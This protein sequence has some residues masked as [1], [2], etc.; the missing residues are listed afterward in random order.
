MKNFSRIARLCAAALA[1]ALSGSPGYAAAD[2][3]AA[4]LQAVVQTL[5]FLSNLSN[6]GA[7]NIGV[8]YAQDQTGSEGRAAQAAA[9]LNA[10]RGPN[11]RA[12]HGTPIAVKDL[13]RATQ[14]FDVYLLMPGTPSQGAA[15]NEAVR[16]RHTVSISTDPACLDANCCVLMVSAQGRV[17]IVLDS[18]L[19]DAAG[20]QFSSVF[21]MMVTRK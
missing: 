2:V 17:R 19:A 20:A 4:E 16:R 12:L 14:P 6:A 5:G 10:M 3:S 7:L 18:A 13:D 15:I 9:Q 21:A 8:V 1:L 11:Q